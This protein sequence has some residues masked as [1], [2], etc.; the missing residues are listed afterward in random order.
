MRVRKARCN[1][2]TEWT[3][4]LVSFSTL[5]NQPRR[6]ERKP[7]G[8]FISLPTANLFLLP[9][10]WTHHCALYLQS[11]TKGSP[12]SEKDLLKA[13]ESIVTYHFFTHSTS[14]VLCC[15][16]LIGGRVGRKTGV[17]FHPFCYRVKNYFTSTQFPVQM[18]LLLFPLFNL[19]G[20]SEIAPWSSLLSSLVK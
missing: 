6:S 15:L 2:G 3:R 20:I 4:D 16:C 13:C 1:Q 19:I 12:T 17:A 8:L 10:L 5:G 18:Y 14:L 9:F 11:R 7:Q